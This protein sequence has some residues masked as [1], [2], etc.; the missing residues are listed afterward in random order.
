MALA[1]VL[2]SCALAGR[3]VDAGAL[4]W[5]SDLALRQPW[6]AL[7]AAGVHYSGLHLAA[8]LAGLLL[9]AALGAAAELPPRAAAAWLAAWPLTQ[10]GL[11]LVPGLARFGGLSGV[12]HAGVCVGAVW[13]VVR[14]VRA[15]RCVGAALLAGCAAKLVAET[16][17]AAPWLRHPSGWDIATAPVAHLSG[18]AAG[19][20]CG[21]LL[22]ARRSRRPQD[23][24]RDG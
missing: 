20:V 21:L 9:T 19:V 6:R 23:S 4:E 3:A 18:C 8:N 11:L 22:A 7:T 24:R 10:L 16:A 5:R 14:G 12:L 1:A 17:W 13:L 15:E 2:A